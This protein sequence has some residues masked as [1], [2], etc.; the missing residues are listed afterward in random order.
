[1]ESYW[2]FKNNTVDIIKMGCLGLYETN[3]YSKKIVSYTNL[4]KLSVSLS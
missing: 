4:T 1:M 2:G 3:N